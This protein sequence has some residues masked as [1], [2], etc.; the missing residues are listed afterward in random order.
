MA[1]KPTDT[2]D[3]FAG[4]PESRVPFGA[5][6]LVR[7]LNLAQVHAV[8]RASGVPVKHFEISPYAGMV[9]V[10]ARIRPECAPVIQAIADA[11]AAA[12]L[13]G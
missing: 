9:L 11:D 8:I 5:Q 1:N 3:R 6:A 2:P 12:P 13:G 4:V 10:R 7:K